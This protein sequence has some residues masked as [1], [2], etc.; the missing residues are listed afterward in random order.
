LEVW[1]ALE[2][3]KEL[4][5]LKTN[6]VSM[7]SHEF[8]TPLGI[9]LSSAQILSDYFG[10]LST[11]ER[12]EH[13]GSIAKNSQL[14]AGLMEE[15]L[16]LS[17]VESGK[18]AFEPAA[19]D[20]ASFCR[21]LVEE[22]RSATRGAS[23]IE[24]AVGPDCVAARADERLLRHIF[25]NIL[26]N[27]VKYSSPGSAV[28]FTVAREKHQAFCRVR[29]HGIGI[30]EED[31][32]RLFTAFHRGRNVGPV[33]GSGLGLVIVKRCVELHSG[34]IRVESKPGE[35]TTVTVHLPLFDETL[36]T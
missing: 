22:V 18:L 20:L 12:L 23:P 6:F 11:E 15:V 25:T 14:M 24:L 28:E 27:A 35:G 32:E 9:I 19:L 34:S 30:P 29:D 2:R 26:V 33:S 7:V 36:K 3:E 5:Q 8:R 13:L 16:V 17:R 21:R 10:Q 31:L 1:R 4:S